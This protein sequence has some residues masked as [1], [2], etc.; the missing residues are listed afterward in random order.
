MSET[1]IEHIYKVEGMTCAHCVAAVT[2][3]VSALPGAQD[4]V[5]DLESGRLALR[6]E[7]IADD[8]VREAVE[9]AG[10]SLV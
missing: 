1:T 7:N 8:A 4:V 2:Q 3:S 10:Y 5:V 9:E 6:G